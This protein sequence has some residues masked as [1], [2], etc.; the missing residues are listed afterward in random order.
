M[1]HGSDVAACAG[2]TAPVSTPAVSTPIAPVANNVRLSFPARILPMSMAGSL[3]GYGSVRSRCSRS[4][5]QAPL[6]VGA[7]VAGPE[8]ELRAVP[9]GRP[10]GVQAQPGLHADDRAA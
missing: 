7:A 3:Q 5:T 1:S 10:V 2:L 4:G 8:D 6:L 9:R